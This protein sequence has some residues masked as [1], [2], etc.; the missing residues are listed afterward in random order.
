MYSVVDIAGINRISERIMAQRRGRDRRHGEGDACRR[1]RRRTGRWS[2]RRCSASRRPA[3]RARASGWRSSATRCSSSTP[4]AR[5]ASRWRRSRAAASSR[6][7]STSTTTELADD[8]VGGVLSAGPDRLDAAGELGLPQVV[9]LGA[10]DMVNFGP[11]ETRPARVPR[12]ESL[13]AQPDG[14]ADADDARGVRRARAPDRP[15]AR[16][17]DGAD[18]AL[19]AAAGRLDDRHEGRRLPR[20]GGR[21]GAARRARTRR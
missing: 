16:R 11:L 9:S 5:A 18:G 19:R 10:L 8:L 7:C 13:R 2:A 3:S 21:R 15:Q 6:A 4:P 17:G 12:P 20:P 1:P 14:H